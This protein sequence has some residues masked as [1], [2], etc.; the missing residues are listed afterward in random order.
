[1]HTWCMSC[2]CVCL[3]F[4]FPGSAPDIDVEQLVGE[5]SVVASFPLS[6]KVSGGR[7]AGLRVTQGTLQRGDGIVR[8]VRQ[9]KV[10]Y[11][12]RHMTPYHYTSTLEHKPWVKSSAEGSLQLSCCPVN[13]IQIV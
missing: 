10:V 5:G 12:V 3:V 1:M 8:V 6:G 7:I 9:G 11:Q 4:P 2:V 13:A